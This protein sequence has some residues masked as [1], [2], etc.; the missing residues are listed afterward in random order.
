MSNENTVFVQIF[1]R[2][3]RKLILKRG[4]EASNYYEHGEE[5]GFHFWRVLS[6]IKGAIYEPAGFWLPENLRIQGT[7]KYVLGV[8]VPFDYK[9]SIPNEMEIITLEECTYLIFQGPSFLPDMME[10]AI[11]E[12]EGTIEN[13][14]PTVYGWRWAD[15]YAPKIEYDPKPERGYIFAR[16]VKAIKSN[17]Y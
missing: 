9:G 12:M 2:P 3:K 6:N 7:S 1:Y 10:Q 5:V 14:D 11:C 13:Y 16:P 17:E 15:E 8:E 4:Y